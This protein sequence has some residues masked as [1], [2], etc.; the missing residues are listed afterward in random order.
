VYSKQQYGCT[1]ETYSRAYAQQAFPS[2]V[3]GGG[4]F[5]LQK[6]QGAGFTPY[7]LQKLSKKQRKKKE[8]EMEA[9]KEAK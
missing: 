1:N 6:M 5:E 2:C 9:K 7:C 3:E 8:K 4:A